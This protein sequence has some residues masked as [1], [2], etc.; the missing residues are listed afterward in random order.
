M[1]RPMI[2]NVRYCDPCRGIFKIVTAVGDDSGPTIKL[3][4]QCTQERFP[5]PVHLPKP[6]KMAG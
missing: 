1:I 3:F 2:I 5:V 6:S 4:G